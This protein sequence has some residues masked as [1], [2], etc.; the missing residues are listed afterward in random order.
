M[1]SRAASVR[2]C[3]VFV[4]INEKRPHGL[5]M[6]L[7]LLREPGISSRGGGLHKPKVAPPRKRL[8]SGH[9]TQAQTRREARQRQSDVQEIAFRRKGHFPP[10][11][12][13][14]HSK[15]KREG[16][17]LT[18]SERQ[19]ENRKW[20]THKHLHTQRLIQHWHRNKHPQAADEAT[21]SGSPRRTTLGGEISPRVCRPTRPGD[22]G[23]RG[24]AR[25]LGRLTR[26]AS[27]WA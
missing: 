23:G 17:K 25:L 27:G 15:R 22:H 18:E 12:P 1:S 7:Q 16:K 26:T 10:L 20:D 21:T 6:R 9:T 19:R 11:P 5:G 4:L 24:G 14:T 8:K 3:S 13:H 2:G